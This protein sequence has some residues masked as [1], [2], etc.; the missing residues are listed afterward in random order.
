MPELLRSPV[1]GIDS[2][3]PCSVFQQSGGTVLCISGWN[4][5]IFSYEGTANVLATGND[6]AKSSRLTLRSS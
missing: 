6:V 5:C 3:W 2:H 1:G 4:Q